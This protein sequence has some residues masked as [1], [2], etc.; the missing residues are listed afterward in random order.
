MERAGRDGRL[1]RPHLM[2]IPLTP[3][4]SRRQTALPERCKP[5]PNEEQDSGPSP[6]APPRAVGGSLLLAEFC[7]GL[8][9]GGVIVRGMGVGEVGEE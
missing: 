4:A 8:F 3:G 6:P 7:G 9:A 2:P 5:R 1:L